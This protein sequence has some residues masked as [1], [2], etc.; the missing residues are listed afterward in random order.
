MSA[1]FRAAVTV[2]AAAVLGC[3][4]AAPLIA[5]SGDPTGGIHCRVVDEQG[6]VLPGVSVT[7]RGPGAAMTSVTDALG[8]FHFIHLSPDNYTIVLEREGFATVN[9]GNVI[10]SVGRDTELTIPMKLSTVTAVITVSDEAPLIDTR[11]VET[12]TAVSRKE[13]RDI[14]TARDP[15]VVLQ[16]IPG[17]QIDRVNVGGSES[18][19]QSIFSSKGSVGGSFQVDGVDM[20]T[21]GSNA[22]YDFDSF[23]EMQVI[24]GGGDAS[25][26][27]A[28]AH[29]NMITKRGTNALHGSARIFVVDHH[30]QSDNLPSEAVGQGLTDGNHIQGIQDNGAEVG[31]PAWKDRLWLWGAYGRDHI[32]LV[33][34]GGVLDRTTLEDFNAKLNAQVVPSNSAEIWYLRSDKVKLGRGGG[35]SRPQPTTWDQTLPQNTWKIQDSQVVSSS[36]FASV[37]YSGQNG[38]FVLSPEGGLSNQAFLDSDGVWHNTYEFYSAAKAQR[39]VKG[40]ASYFFNTGKLGHELKAGFNYLK[41]GNSSASVWAGD[42]SGGLAAQTYG[43]LLDC[44]VPCAVITRNGSFGTEAKYWGA[45]L[46][47]TVTADRLTVNLGLRWDEQYG[48]NRASIVP[49]N[50][51]FPAILPA[52]VYSGRGRDFT[53]RDWQP[54]VGLAYALGAKRNTVFK[55]SY[56]RYAQALDPFTVTYT[57]NSAGAAYAY[58]AWNDA[59]GDHLV[60]QNEV[61]TSPAGF[62]Y[63]RNY[64]PAN[65]GSPDNPF[66]AIDPHLRAPRTDEIIVGLEHELLPALAVGINYTHRKFSGELYAPF[67]TFDPTASYRLTGSDYEQYATLTG[68]TPDGVAYSEPVY[69]IKESVLDRLG[70]CAADPN[71]GLD[72]QAPAGTFV[73]NRRNFNTTYDGV[74]LVLTKRLAG[75][76]MARGNFVYNNDRQHLDASQACVDPT[77]LFNFFAP[78]NAQPCRNDLVAAFGGKGAVFLNSKWQFNLVGLYQLPWDFAL[79]ANVYGRQGYPINWYRQAP[80]NGT[81]GVTRIVFVAP[82]GTSRYS[83]VFELDLR[84]EKTIHITRTFTVTLSADLFNATN[85]GTVLQ[86]QNRIFVLADGSTVDP[87]SNT[88]QIREIQSPR[89][90][91]F[92]VRIAF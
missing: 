9:R 49:A 32:D 20:G 34:A 68:T 77:N 37:L 39:Q 11:R 59:N 46:A 28:N 76:W 16:T 44:S 12:G 18:G 14:P 8:E 63:P 69:R 42:G 40:D 19:G 57:N 81:D 50:A 65:P 70:L 6:G 41:I 52:F 17:I 35:L 54:R 61:D 79:A 22:Y 78:V 84:A 2:T 87:A 4:M 92:G 31:G 48:T 13:L 23:Q 15:W 82:A 47:D 45:F 75:R 29:L 33:T 56:S 90:W 64:N 43:D 67:Y 25:I 53:W 10:V 24:T 5:Q 85:Q 71:G 74:E 30:F 58:Y 21:G 91:R 83:D 26:K 80:A 60:Q 38:D 86:R 72:C 89:I 27:G 7:L 55:A 62:Q 1:P 88:N 73:T 36:F 51:T 3:L 66:N